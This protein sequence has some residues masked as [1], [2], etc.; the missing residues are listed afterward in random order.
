MEPSLWLGSNRSTYSFFS[1]SWIRHGYYVWSRY[2]ENA[3]IQQF[4]FIISE[5]NLNFT[6]KNVNILSIQRPFLWIYIRGLPNSNA[7]RKTL[8]S[9]NQFQKYAP[10]V[11]R[12]ST[13]IKKILL[14]NRSELRNNNFDKFSIIAWWYDPKC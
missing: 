3:R 6:I 12:N 9:L 4:G 13:V 7:D 1:R 11:V 8:Y 10:M 2:W 5:F 14:S